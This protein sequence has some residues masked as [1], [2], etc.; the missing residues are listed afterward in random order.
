MDFDAHFHSTSR[1]VNDEAGPLSTT[2]PIVEGKQHFESGA[3]AFWS[4]SA[5]ST[6]VTSGNNVC[7]QTAKLVPH[8]C[9]SAF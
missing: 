7:R 8:Q 5:A 9:F 2:E 6:Y 4:F 3:N 1:H